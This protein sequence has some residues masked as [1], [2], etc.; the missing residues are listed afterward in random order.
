MNTCNVTGSLQFM[1]GDPVPGSFIYI[2]TPLNPLFIITSTSAVGISF[3]PQ[4]YVTEDDGSFSM[5]LLCNGTFKVIIKDIG[6]RATFI[7]PNQD[8]ADLFS[9]ISQSSVS[10]LVDALVTSTGIVNGDT[11]NW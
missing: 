7:V 1:S 10:P 5:P 8:T 11:S 9:L 3:Q 6:L 2:S 4:M